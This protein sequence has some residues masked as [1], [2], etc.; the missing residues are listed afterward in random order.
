MTG[1][2]V[3]VGEVDGLRFATLGRPDAP[4]KV[5]MFMGFLACVEAFELQRFTLLSEI[6]DARVTVVDAPGCGYG[7]GRLRSSER[8]ALRRGDF[9]AVAD[10]MVAVALT[11]KPDLGRGPVTIV[12]YSMGSSIAA[13]AAGSQALRVD[14][15]TLV[16]PVAVK[17][18][19]LP[20]LVHATRNED[21]VLDEYLDRN[22]DIPQVVI[23]LQRRDETPPQQSRTDLAHLGFA[24]SRG[25]LAVDVQRAHR[26]HRFAMQLVHG[27]RSRLAGCCDVARFAQQCRDDGV[28]TD[29]IVVHGRHAL[30]HSLP[31]V[32]HLARAT[33]SRW[34]AAPS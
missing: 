13:A 12:G 23:P 24:L 21:K 25:Y 27:A 15:L 16:E 9:T 5:L 34:T 10:R 29:D 7:S 32:A 11:A 1:G 18:W 22:N 4:R 19:N 3:T 17:R 30:W 14:N 8:R 28:A 20:R 6:W 26:T 2:T 33:M 31:D